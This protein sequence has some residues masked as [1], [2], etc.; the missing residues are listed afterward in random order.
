[1]K[2]IFFFFVFETRQINLYTD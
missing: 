2:L 1:M